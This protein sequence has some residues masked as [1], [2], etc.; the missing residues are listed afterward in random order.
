SPFAMPEYALPEAAVARQLDAE[1]GELFREGQDANQHSDDYVL[2]T[3]VL[4][5][6]LLLVGL[7]P[8]IGWVPARIALASVA[9]VVFALGIY[10]IATYPI[11]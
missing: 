3:V 8:R 6:T 10:N 1:A 5:S 2:N 11:E 4:A 9:L 7:A